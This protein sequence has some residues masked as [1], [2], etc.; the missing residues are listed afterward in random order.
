MYVT[1][2]VNSP[3]EDKLRDT[4]KNI[5]LLL[6]LKIILSLVHRAGK[7]NCDT[8]GAKPRKTRSI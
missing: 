4:W 2:D 1:T 3:M 6:L 7:L 8:H 5:Q